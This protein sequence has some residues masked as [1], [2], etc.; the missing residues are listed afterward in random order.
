MSVYPGSCPGCRCWPDGALLAGCST[1]VHPACLRRADRGRRDVVRASEAPE[2]GDRRHGRDGDPDRR[3]RAAER[4]R[5][6]RAASLRLAQ[7]PRLFLA[8]TT[9]EVR[10]SAR[11]APDAAALRRRGPPPRATAARRVVAGAAA[12]SSW[13]SDRGCPARAPRPGSRGPAAVGKL[14]C[15]VKSNATA[16][17][18]LAQVRRRCHATRAIWVPSGRIPA[19]SP[20]KSYGATITRSWPT[21]ASWRRRS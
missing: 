4:R 5:A 18:T 20:G 21:S 10:A 9:F 16:R 1:S 6:S 8:L 3:E 15:D 11:G 14:Y 19:A 17:S 12:S 13:P 2:Q 7:P